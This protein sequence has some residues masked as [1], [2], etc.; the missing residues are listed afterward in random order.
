MS[1][2]K[3]KQ[4]R[5]QLQFEQSQV[6]NVTQLS[7]WSKRAINLFIYA[8]LVLPALF[9]VPQAINAF[10]LPKRTLFVVLAVWLVFFYIIYKLELKEF[11]FKKAQRAILII[12]GSLVLFKSVSLLFSPNKDISFWGSYIR[13]EGFVVFLFLALFF[14]VL[15]DVIRSEKQ[16]HRFMFAAS[17]IGTIIAVY[18][19]LQKFG[20]DFS[21]L[22]WGAGAYNRIA[23]TLGNPLVLAPFLI[24]TLLFSLILIKRY[25]RARIF[26]VIGAII[27]LLAIIYTDNA[28]A[29]LAITGLV[30]F[31]LFFYFWPRKKSVSVIIL[32]IAILGGTFLGLAAFEKINQPGVQKY[33]GGFSVYQ[34]SNLQRL[35]A[36]ET[37]W[38][39]FL[40]KPM[41]GWGNESFSDAYGYA[42]NTNLLP[43]LES[44]FDRAHNL[45][46]DYLVMEGALVALLLIILLIYAIVTGLKKYFKQKQIEYLIASSLVFAF[47]INFSF[48]ITTVISSIILFFTLALIFYQKQEQQKQFIARKYENKFVTIYTIA[49]IGALILSVYVIKPLQADLVYS[50]SRQVQDPNKKLKFME[51]AAGIWGYKEYKGEVLKFN[52]LVIEHFK[53][54]N[55]DAAKAYINK[56]QV[57]VDDLITRYPNQYMS[58]MLVANFYSSTENA[59]QVNQHYQTA[60]ELA[61]RQFEVYWLWGDALLKLNQPEQAIEKHQAAIDIDPS[62]PYPYKKMAELYEQIEDEEQFQHYMEEY[63]QRGG[64]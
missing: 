32:L 19:V 10:E 6:E 31:L 62:Q 51:Q 24:F 2:K 37:S 54:N 43:P 23:S 39:A 36:W 14:V 45:F 58:H 4:N 52:T 25:K 40:V 13:Q 34:P 15:I 1:K 7:T 47:V 33:L 30:F 17:S 29:Y 41:F 16:M 42:K 22:T 27:Q 64:E 55:P 9:F 57:L 59:D 48:S 12:L 26:L 44:N 21:F 60:A 18:G 28:S 53:Q 49:L 38:Q 20:I 3:H 11:K 50:K 5:K 46:F 8:I 35:Y 61:P 63:T 56:S